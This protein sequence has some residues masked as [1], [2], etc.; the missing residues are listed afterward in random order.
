MRNLVNGNKKKRKLQTGGGTER[1]LRLGQRLSKRKTAQRSRDKSRTNSK[2]GTFSGVGCKIMLSSL[3]SENTCI[4]F[5][6]PR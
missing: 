1:R 3:T 6:L 5:L 2:D 4:H